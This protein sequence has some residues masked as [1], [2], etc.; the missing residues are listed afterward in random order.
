MERRVLLVGQPNVGKSSIL[1]A[2]T[3][4]R[5]TVSN[6]PGTTVDI[7][8]GRTEVKGI[9]YVLIDTPGIYNLFPSSMEEEITE[10]AVIKGEYEFIINVVDATAIE[11]NL[12]ITAALAELGVPMIIA[13]NF[14]EEA[15]KKGIKIDYKKLEKSLGVPIVKV[16]PFKRGGMRE[17]ISHIDKFRKPLFHVRYN[18]HIEKAIYS[19]LGCIK[20]DKLD[21]R[22]VAARLVEGD[23]IFRSLFDCE[24]VVE[25]RKWLIDQGHNPQLDV[26]SS[27]A[28]SAFMLASGVTHVLPTPERAGPT[29]ALDDLVLR[30]PFIGLIFSLLLLF[31]IIS[32]VIYGGG[33]IQDLLVSIT[34][35]WVSYISRLAYESGKLVGKLVETSLL[36]L[37]GQYAAAVP[38][39]FL[40]YAILAILEDSGILAREIVM[41]SSIFDRIG[42]HAKSVIPAMLGLGCS[43][44]A[45]KSTR[46]LPS[47]K[48]RMKTIFLFLFIP[49]S[50]RAVTIFGLTGRYLGPLWAFSVYVVGFALGLITVKLLDFLPTFEG[51]ELYVIEELPPYR[52][53][54]AENIAL[55]SWMRFKDFIIIVTPLVVAGAILYTFIDYS[56]LASLVVD[57]L[58]PLVSYWLGLPPNAAVPLVYGFLQKDIV[59]GM[60]YAVL[61]TSNIASILTPYQIYSFTLANTFQLPCIIAFLMIWREL[62][63]KTALITFLTG[64]SYGMLWAGLIGRTLFFFI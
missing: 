22:G 61:G 60:L 5:A 2:L 17:L 14:W 55:K 12:I 1:N 43:V 25:V 41:L 27:R 47:I 4:A 16:N 7:T 24:R 40:F 26:E 13:V 42:L 49:C 45:I 32:L 28:A 44:P 31:I 50:S 35:P 58:K 15:E 8:L 34:D 59:I 52:M 20:G 53:P 19:L 23:P 51:E 30:R 64:I 33:V 39:V 3:G 36:A 38:Y 11:R 9:R 62:G 10:M 21:K 56:G 37:E 18:D 48:Q 29:S 54:K 57:P 6:Y 46:V 63:W